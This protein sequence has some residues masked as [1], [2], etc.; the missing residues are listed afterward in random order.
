M[1]KLVD[2]YFKALEVV[3][4]LCLAA[5]CLM[6]FGNVV[7]RHVFDSG[8]NISEELSRFMFIWLIFLGAILAMREGGH[9][10]MDM[11]VHR[12]SGRSLF[13][14][15][16]I[17]QCI[18]LSCCGVLLWGLLRQHALNVANTGLVTGIS[19]SVVYSV[20]Y[21]CAASIGLMTLT[22]ILRLISGRV[23]PAALIAV[24]EERA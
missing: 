5:M 16:L 19:L 17:A 1:K 24:S 22:N 2:W 8:I 6:V 3:V 11:L 15:V 9:L 13:A 7:L 21:L 4:V 18:T 23:S 14:A 20:A 12:L 10:G